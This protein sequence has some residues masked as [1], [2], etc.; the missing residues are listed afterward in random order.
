MA[1]EERLENQVPSDTDSDS[2]AGLPVSGGADKPLYQRANVAKEDDADLQ[3]LADKHGVG[4]VAYVGSYFGV[5]ISPVH[6]VTPSIELFD[7]FCIEQVISEFDRAG[8]KKAYFLINS[9]GGALDSAYKIAKGLRTHLQ[10]IITFVPHIAASGGTL[11]ALTGNKIVMS[12]MSNISPLDPQLRYRGTYISAT[13]GRRAFNRAVRF[14]EKRSVDET[15]YPLRQF[16]EMLDPY[17]LTQWD[18]VCL[19]ARMYIEEILELVGYKDAGQIADKL[20]WNFPT[21]SHV[22]GADAAKALDLNIED[23]S[24]H[25]IQ[26]NC[27]RDWLRRYLFE[28]QAENVIRYVLPNAPNTHKTAQPSQGGAAARQR[29]S[30]NRKGTRHAKVR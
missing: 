28:P 6:T 29:Q 19:T 27:M 20:I 1:A 13:A 14:F 25:Q 18:N 16:S 5:R 21:H 4:L 23:A 12:S 11:L 9:F 10:E 15:P 17:T 22:I 8:G 2:P 3:A 7:E 26:W 30:A 24:V